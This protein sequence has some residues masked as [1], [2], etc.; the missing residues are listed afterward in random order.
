MNTD[1]LVQAVLAGCERREASTERVYLNDLAIRPCQA[2]RVQDG[3]GC[4]QRDDMDVVYD[5]FREA[6]GLVIGTPVYYGAVSSQIKLMI[7]RSYCLAE[8]VR[9][10]TG[11]TVYQ[12]MVPKRKKGVLICVAGGM[13]DLECIWAAFGGWAEEVNLEPTEWPFVSHA[14]D[15]CEPKDRKRL[16]DRLTRCGEGLSEAVEATTVAE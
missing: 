10:S 14:D 5:A 13:L 8:A 16:L 3:E 2:C 12:T 15:E 6:D 1:V 4:R 11:K 9:L 7:D